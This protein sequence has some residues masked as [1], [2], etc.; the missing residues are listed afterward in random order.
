M[1]FWHFNCFFLAYVDVVALMGRGGCARKSPG[2][3][4]VS[5]VGVERDVLRV[6]AGHFG[7]TDQFAEVELEVVGFHGAEAGLN[8][9]CLAVFDGLERLPNF[10]QLHTLLL[11]ENIFSENL[12][13]LRYC[14]D[15]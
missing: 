14:L 15:S 1:F 9:D 4:P 6:D 11:L 2:G 10:L 13:A 8:V 5:G 7:G 3:S 12:E